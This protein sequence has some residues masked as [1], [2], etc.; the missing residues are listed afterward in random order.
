MKVAIMQPYTFP[1]IG[2]FQLI[3][4]ADV[5]VFYDDVNFIKKG[6]VNRNYILNQGIRSVFTI[7]CKGIS[8]NKKINETVVNLDSDFISKIIKTLEHNYKK[9]PFYD[10][11]FPL[12][13]NYF[14]NFEGKFISDFAIGSVLLVCDYLDIEKVFKLSSKT[15]DNSELKKENRL[16]DIVLKEDAEIYIN[17]IGGKTLYIKEKF[18]NNGIELKFLESDHIEYK[19]FNEEFVPW[20]SII[21]VMMFNDKKTILEFLKQYKL[22]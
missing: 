4:A 21:D 2:Y 12:I 17:A 10:D 20:L 19:Q 8:Q 15:Y 1:Y 14:T 11:V 9:A 6:F 22:T 3:Y 18:L 7:P 13:R 5:F 16:I